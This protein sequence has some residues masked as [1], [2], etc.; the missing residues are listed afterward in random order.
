VPPGVGYTTVETKVN[1]TRA[2][3]ADTG[4]VRAEG[5]VVNRGRQIMSAEGRLLDT[6]GRLL[7]HGTSTLIVLGDRAVVQAPAGK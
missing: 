3:K 2:I 1:F 5:R 7:A 6:E 4:R